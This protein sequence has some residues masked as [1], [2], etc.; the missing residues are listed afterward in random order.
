MS[1]LP[2][3]DWRVAE[4]TG[5]SIIPNGPTPAPEQIA[6]VVA[7][8]RNAAER[9][10][11]HV[12]EV[13][14]FTASVDD[15][16]VLVVDRPTWLA[17]NV[18]SVR[19]VL[20]QRDADP[21]G[22]GERAQG[23]LLGAQIGA[24]LAWVGTRIL[25]QFDPFSDQPKLMLVAPNVLHVERELNVDPADFRLWV[26][27]HEQTHRF[28]F[29][30]APWL[31]EYLME[32]AGEV[33]DEPT[34][35]ITW[36]PGDKRPASLVDLV[37]TPKQREAINVVTGVMS[38]L[39]GHADVMMD[40]VG[41]A[42]VPSVSDIRAKFTERRNRKGFDKV[43]RQV[44]GL[45]MKMAQYRDGANFCR[46]VM[47]AIGVDGLNQAFQ[48]VGYLPSYDEIMAPQLWIERMSR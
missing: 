46:A 6:D 40:R 5:R 42:V 39:E 26:C 7:A 12:R 1:S 38:L 24:A 34:Q 18:A 17:A 2:P 37:S 33:L 13:T 23:M 31:R 11:P 41:P 4:Q 30:Q 27:L 9:A 14:Q 16:P 35:G 10:T 25:G 47:D 21:T 45:D 48:S 19:A 22:L 43:M 3:I 32:L 28:Q 20:G 8:L 44:L 36:R 29:A 15:L